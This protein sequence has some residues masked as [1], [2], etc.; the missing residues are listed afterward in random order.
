[1]VYSWG[2]L[3]HTGDMWQG[4]SNAALAVARGG[5]LFIAIYNDQG[6]RWDGWRKVKQLYCSG[7]L[8]RALVCGFFIP[9][10]VARGA[11]GDLPRGRN[12]FRRYLNQAEGCRYST[13][14]S[15]GL[16]ASPSRWRSPKPSCV[17]PLARIR[18]A[19]VRDGRRR[20]GEQSVPL[21]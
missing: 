5:C 19:H 15:I 3:H 12:P 8:G 11:V 21:R 20:T 10:F 18:T 4:L 6:A 14:R 2:V 13:I 1:M 16:V 7:L 9:Y 17:L